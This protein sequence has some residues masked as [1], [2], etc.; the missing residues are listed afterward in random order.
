MRSIS[1]FNKYESLVGLLKKILIVS[2][3]KDFQ[4]FIMDNV[5]TDVAAALDLPGDETPK[6]IAAWIFMK[7]DNPDPKRQVRMSCQGYT[8]STALR[9]RAAV[10]FHY[11]QLGRSGNWSQ[12]LDGSWSGNPSLSTIVSRYMLS[13]QR[14]KV[15]P[16]NLIFQ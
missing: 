11:N 15:I 9:M 5:G 3:W 13:L 16:L 8:F 12:M 4:Q 1:S 10:S 6:M 7:C 14:R 2:T